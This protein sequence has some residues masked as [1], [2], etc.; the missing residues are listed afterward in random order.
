[1]CSVFYSAVKRL[2]LTPKK[3][4]KEKVIRLLKHLLRELR[5]LLL[6]VREYFVRMVGIF[7][8]SCIAH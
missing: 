7:C 1:M 4:M 8:L 5:H 2:S 6:A 3:K